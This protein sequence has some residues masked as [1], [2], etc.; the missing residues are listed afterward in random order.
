MH[1]EKNNKSVPKRQIS[2][3]GASKESKVI[4]EKLSLLTTLVGTYKLAENLFLNITSNVNNK[5]FRLIHINIA[6]KILKY[7]YEHNLV[8]ESK[9]LFSFQ[10]SLIKYF[11]SVTINGK[12][13]SQLA[14]ITKKVYLYFISV[15]FFIQDNDSKQFNIFDICPQNASDVTAQLK[16]VLKTICPNEEILN[17]TKLFIRS[18]NVEKNYLRV[19]VNAFQEISSIDIHWSKDAIEQG[20]N[21]FRDSYDTELGSMNTKYYETSRAIEL[22][23][24]LKD[25]GLLDKH[26][27]LTNNI[28]KPSKSSLM[29][30]TNPTIAEINIDEV[31]KEKSLTSAKSLI[32]EFYANLVHRLDQMVSIAQETVFYYYQIKLPHLKNNQKFNG[33]ENE[34]ASAM[35]LIITDEEG[36]NPT[37]LYNLKVKID[38]NSPNSKNEFIKIEDDGTVRFNVIK[39]RQRR[40]QKRTTDASK[41]APPTDINPRN[42]NASFCIQFAIELT[43]KKRKELKTNLLWIRKSQTILRKDNSFDCEFRQFCTNNLPPEFSNLKPTLMKVRTSRAIEIYIRTDGDVVAAATYLGNKV[44]TT[45]ST[46]IPLFLQEIMYRRKISVFQ[47]IYLILA[48]ALE[49]EKLKLLGMSQESYDKCILEIYDNK[50]FGGPLFEKLKPIVPTEEKV[51]SE[52]FFVC[53]VENFAFIINYLKHEKDDGSEFYTVCKNALNKAVSASIQHKKMIR[54][55]ELLLDGRGNSHE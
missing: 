29:R 22:F 44:K 15:D 21:N 10:D 14:N 37:S 1:T 32:D 38:K 53:S 17:A 7:H 2:N 27:R 8:E 43:E 55:A 19:F 6:I 28:K 16:L 35:Q 34:L 33:L 36:I 51:E 18:K 41:L 3:D 13:P 26:I 45:L 48:T 39:W 30:S 24:H 12:L 31:N 42:I 25:I 47:H 50:D 20:L 54:D 4:Q 52:Y 9:R 40:L 5:G 46:Y 49:P 23:Q 11:E